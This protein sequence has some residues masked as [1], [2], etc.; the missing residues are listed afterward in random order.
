MEGDLDPSKNYWSGSGT[1][2]GIIRKFVPVLS[3]QLGRR[4]HIRVFPLFI[5]IVTPLSTGLLI[6]NYLFRIRIW[7]LYCL[8]TC[9]KGCA[10]IDPKW[11][12]PDPTPYPAKS[13]GSDRIRIHNTY[14]QSA[15]LTVPPSCGLPEDLLLHFMNQLTS[16]GESAWNVNNF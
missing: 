4:Y 3:H 14:W 11:F 10:R 15:C 9:K 1:L 8:L 12:I 2:L 16:D 5:L 7:I 13:Y 6:R